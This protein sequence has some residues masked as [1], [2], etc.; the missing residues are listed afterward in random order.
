MKFTIYVCALYWQFVQFDAAVAF[1][2]TFLCRN[3][4]IDK[5]HSKVIQMFPIPR[6]NLFSK[7]LENLQER[8]YVDSLTINGVELYDIVSYAI[9]RVQGCI[10]GEGRGLVF[11]THSLVVC[12][13]MSPLVHQHLLP[14]LP[15][16]HYLQLWTPNFTILYPL[17]GS[18]MTHP[19]TPG[20]KFQNLIL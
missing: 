10:G 14:P 17:L 16:A 12:H 2:T 20:T 4:N 9:F 15:P 11:F 18:L 3:T 13:C 5:C 1:G 6:R 7:K 19:P 8:Q